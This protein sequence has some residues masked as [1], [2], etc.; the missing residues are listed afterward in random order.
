MDLK[1]Q[2]RSL[3]YER[4]PNALVFE[5]IS[6]AFPDASKD[7]LEKV[8]SELVREGFLV[9]KNYQNSHYPKFNRSGHHISAKELGEF[10]VETEIQIGDFKIPRMLDGDI[11]RAE[12]I[13]CIAMSF[14]KVVTPQ[15]KDVKQ[16][17][18]RESRSYWGRLITVFGLLV[19]LFSLINVSVKP[20]YFSS[21]LK[22]TPQEMLI[23]SACNIAPLA[24][25]LGI[26]LLILWVMFRRS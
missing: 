26:F 6:Y 15:I 14:E 21:D 11:V 2:I 25:V 10:P 4:A 12:D 7:E 3:F 23:Q 18:Q 17:I 19:A 24:I 9:P 16:Q 13:N 20:I 22:L 1:G 8:L 5:H